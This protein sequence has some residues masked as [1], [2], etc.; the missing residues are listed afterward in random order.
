MGALFMATGSIIFSM[1]HFIANPPSLN[2]TL[3]YRAP[4]QMPT[5]CTNGPIFN[6]NGST[7]SPLGYQQEQVEECL[8]DGKASSAQYVA[9]LMF[10]QVL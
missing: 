9:V 8:I 3:G 4:G 10:A 5:T 6:V 1:P 7:I 2:D